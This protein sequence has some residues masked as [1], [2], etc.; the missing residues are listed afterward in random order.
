MYV[1][2]LSEKKWPAERDNAMADKK[3]ASTQLKVL[4][5]VHT[6]SFD[7]GFILNYA[8]FSIFP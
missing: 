7:V 5:D 4:T 6:F 2:V 8:I 3:Y 1:K